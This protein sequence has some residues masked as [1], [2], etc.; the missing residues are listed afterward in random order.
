MKHLLTMTGCAPPDSKRHWPK[1]DDD[2]LKDLIKNHTQTEVAEIMGRNIGSIA[3][4]SKRLGLDAYALKRKHA[5]EQEKILKS[6]V[7]DVLGILNMSLKDF[8]VTYDQGS[9]SKIH[10]TAIHN[11]D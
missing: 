3:A 4:R 5:K 7:A 8:K 2:Q 9:R 6:K 11:R 1:E 10:I